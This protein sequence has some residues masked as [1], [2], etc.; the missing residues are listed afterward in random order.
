MNND[1]RPNLKNF[2]ID[3]SL[4]TF[5]TLFIISTTLS[6][7]SWIENLNRGREKES[8]EAERAMKG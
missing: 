2:P 1:K 3:G 8:T 4:I 5:E 6:M 7:Q